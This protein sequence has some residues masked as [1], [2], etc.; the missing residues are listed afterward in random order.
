MKGTLIKRLGVLI[1]VTAVMQVVAIPMA[2]AAGEAKASIS[3]AQ[4]TI[5]AGR[6]VDLTFTLENPT[7]LDGGSALNFVTIGVQQTAFKIVNGSMT[8]WD[9][10]LS[11]TNRVTFTPKAATDTLLPGQT[12]TITVTAQAL[13]PATDRQ[14]VWSVQTDSTGG[15]SVDPALPKAPGDLTTTTRILEVLDVAIVGDSRVTDRTVTS[16]QSGVDIRAIVSNAGSAPLT[17]TPAALGGLGTG[18]AVTPAPAIV[19]AEGTGEFIYSTTFGAPGDV[20]P[21][22]DVSA[23][24]ADGISRNGSVITVQT[25]ATA[26]Y[27]AN[28]L[29]PRVAVPGQSYPFA[30]TISKA[31][32]VALDL[33]TSSTFSI[34]AFSAPLAAPVSFA[35]GS[36]E[37]RL[38]FVD[39][40]IPTAIVDGTYTPVVALAGTDSNGAPVSILPAVSDTVVLDRLAPVVN[41]VATPPAPKVGSEA[42]TTDGAT[43]TFS[44]QVLENST[45]TTCTGCSI[46]TAYLLQRSATGAPL[47]NIPVTVTISNTGV[48]GG[49]YNGSYD[50]AA[51]EINLVVE[52][53]KRTGTPGSGTSDPVAVDNIAP[54]VRE[55]TTGGYDG[56]ADRR[57]VDVLLSEAITDGGQLR[58]S[59]WSVQENTVQAVTLNDNKT[60]ATLT[61]AR[62][63]GR[64]SKPSVSYAP[65][66]ASQSTDRVG[67]NLGPQTLTALDGIVPPAPVFDTVAGVAAQTGKF[68]TNDPTPT[69]VLSN[70]E[71]GQTVVLYEDLNNNNARDDMDRYL[72][73]ATTSGSTVTIDLPDL[74]TSSRVV[75]LL[76]E[77]EDGGGNVSDAAL[78]A[79]QLDF[80]A[81]AAVQ[82]VLTGTTAT[83][84]FGEIIVGRDAGADWVV[85]TADRL[86]TAGTVSVGDG[87]Q[88]RAVAFNHPDY[89]GQSGVLT[90]DYIGPQGQRY[91]DLAGNYVGAIS[92]QI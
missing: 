69:V 27:K 33:A 40:T 7:V 9:A 3:A 50:P 4:R 83:V 41:A 34:G 52:A 64:D 11:G 22:V 24:G 43:L 59:A 39:T 46:R 70:V 82:A 53:A 6:Q 1:A 12:K 62:D 57:R 72:A 58:A 80:E 31:G 81:P 66:A 8:G 65:T 2:F 44:G 13:R 89:T 30:L 47:A 45:A 48:L 84:S 51:T 29:T 35:G 20:T 67:K 25:P 91:K 73:E 42:A 88:S 79:L 75:A 74:G 26:T 16:G 68:Y 37:G 54:T 61:L 21:S 14:T 86:F 5:M 15:S 38:D 10:A 32:Q 92:F 60:I 36:S 19:P 28:T 17:V 85:E 76:A 63:L 49:S 18:T 87:G 23:P 55:A 71:S 56:A 90:Y 77:T 78:A